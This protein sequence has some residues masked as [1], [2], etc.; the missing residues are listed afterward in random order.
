MGANIQQEGDVAV[1]TGVPYLTGTQVK[2]SDLRA[3]A[4]L[5][6]A[7]LQARGI[8]EIFELHHIDRGYEHLVEKLAG[9]GAN[10]QRVPIEGSPVVM[11][12]L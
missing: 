7:G 3:G 4:A 10:I 12:A 2:A 1:V 11:P 9:I 5:V 6:I 8:T